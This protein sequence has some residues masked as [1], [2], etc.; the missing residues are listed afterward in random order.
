[1]VGCRVGEVTGC[2]VGRSECTGK[3]GGRGGVGWLEC[4]WVGDGVVEGGA[5]NDTA[6]ISMVGY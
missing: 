5:T 1:M 3:G 4:L 6:H 2:C